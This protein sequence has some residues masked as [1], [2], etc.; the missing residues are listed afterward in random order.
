MRA[1]E[2]GRGDRHVADV[3]RVD[4]G[5]VGHVEH[6]AAVAA[7]AGE[8]RL[9]L[10]LS[11]LERSLGYIQQR[12]GDGDG[13]AQSIERAMSMLETY[14]NEH[15]KEASANAM[16]ARAHGELG[17]RLHARGDVS[18]AVEHARSAR[19]ILEQL[20]AAEPTNARYQRDLIYVLNTGSDSLELASDLQGANEARRRSHQLA[21]ALVV[22]DPRAQGDQIYLTYSRQAALEKDGRLR[23]G[24]KDSLERFRAIYAQ[25]PG[26]GGR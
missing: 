21:Q 13:A 9:R 7:F 1:V 18:R 14:R 6:P 12:R 22:A 24:S 25:C 4:E 17:E 10:R 23:G 3:A 5:E 16:L 8:R 19:S 20:V 15:P 2:A 26:Q 11:S